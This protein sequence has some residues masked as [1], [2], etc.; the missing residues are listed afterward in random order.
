M[1]LGEKIDRIV[2]AFADQRR[3]EAQRDAVHRAEAE[4]D[5]R[6]AGQ[7]AARH[8]QEPQREHAQRAI[9]REQHG[10]DE[11]GGDA[12]ESATRRLDRGRACSPKKRRGRVKTRRAPRGVGVA[13]TRRSRKPR[14]CSRSRV[15]ARRCRS[16]PRASA[17]PAARAGRRARTTRRRCLSRFRRR[18]RASPTRRSN[19]PVGSPASMR[20]RR[21]PA[22]EPRSAGLPRGARAARA[23]RNA[24]ASTAG[25]SR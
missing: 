23:A 22:G 8:R 7:R 18:L 16:P 1:R 20:C 9:Q 15:P 5:R 14:G 19:S 13:L 25:L 4:A 17:R 6:D 10:A 2:D 21:S 12:R 24:P 11:C 3:A